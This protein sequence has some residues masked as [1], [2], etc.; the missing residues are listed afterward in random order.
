MVDAI[1]CLIFFL[2]PR[3]FL[4]CWQ[5][6]EDKCKGTL[7]LDGYCTPPSDIGIF[8]SDTFMVLEGLQNAS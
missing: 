4:F 5:R 8:N 6:L 7:S 1:K 3:I 2:Y